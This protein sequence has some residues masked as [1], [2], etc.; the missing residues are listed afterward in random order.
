MNE[1]EAAMTSHDKGVG[2]AKV[3]ALQLYLKQDE[4]ALTPADQVEWGTVQ[5]PDNLKYTAPRTNE[6]LQ[7]EIELQAAEYPANPSERVIR[8]LAMYAGVHPEGD[9]ARFFTLHRGL[10]PDIIH[11][12]VQ[13]H[14]GDR[15]ARIRAVPSGWQK[16]TPARTPIV[17]TSNP[18]GD[19]VDL[20]FD[21]PSED[22][23]HLYTANVLSP[24]TPT[25]LVYRTGEIML[26][27]PQMVCPL[28]CAFCIHKHL[29]TREFGLVNFSPRETVDYLMQQ[30]EEGE[31]W[32]SLPMIKIITGAFRNYDHLRNYTKEFVAYMQSATEGAFDPVNND[33]QTIHLLTNLVQSADEMEEIRALGVGSLEHS[34]EIFDDKKRRQQ[35]YRATKNGKVPGKGEQPF[36]ELVEAARKGVDVYGPDNY[37]LGIVMGLDEMDTTEKGLGTLHKAGVRQLTGGIFVP[38][39]YSELSLQQMSFSEIM[40]ARRFAAS[41]FK[42]PNIFADYKTPEQTT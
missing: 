19:A 4:Q 3:R 10:S 33:H 12:T 24:A 8:G 9:A 27:N 25:P 42:L 1:K 41:L 31:D 39:A 14:I 36:N 40:Q 32:G 29:G 5:P 34:L 16:D 35:M 37:A 15:S 17:A 13:L 28:E 22:R 23:R 11:P 21:E 7:R 2:S 30:A 26:I 20:W 6:D 38:N 18:K